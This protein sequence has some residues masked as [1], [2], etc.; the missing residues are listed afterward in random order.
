MDKLLTFFI[1]GRPVPK[2]RPRMMRN[3]GIFTPERTVNY[4]KKVAEAWNDKFGML[5]LEGKLR[6]TINAYTDR[7]TVQDIDNIAKSVL[8]GMQ[9]AGAFSKG[10]AQVYSLGAIKH[11]AVKT[12]L[13]V[14]VSVT[15]LAEYA[16]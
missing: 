1:E 11:A 7:H 12:E 15:A 2:E 8:D 9:R 13:G 16:D 3:G 10:D 5:S 4:E 14:W 6:V